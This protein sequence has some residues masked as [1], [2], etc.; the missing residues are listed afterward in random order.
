M[1]IS[2]RRGKVRHELKRL[3]HDST[4]YHVVHV[5]TSCAATCV[6]MFIYTTYLK[7]LHL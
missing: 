4:N 6:E 5:V 3:H 2:F 7:D 1:L